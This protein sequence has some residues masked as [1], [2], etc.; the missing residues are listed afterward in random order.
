VLDV[1]GVDV[2]ALEE[3]MTLWQSGFNGTTGPLYCVAYLSGYADGSSRIYVAMHHLLVD[4]VSW[5]ILADDL[6]HLYEGQS[7]G[8]KGSSYRQWVDVLQDYAEYHE[9]E[10][11]YWQEVVADLKEIPALEKQSVLSVA[12]LELGEEF[13]SFLLREANGA[14]HTQINDLLLTALAYALNDLSGESVHHVTLEGHG[15]EDIA[16]SIDVTRTVG[17]FTSLYPVRLALGDDLG[18]S[19]KKIKDNI[20]QI[21]NKGIGYG[22]LL[23]YAIAQMPV[24]SFNYLGQFE[25]QSEF[26]HVVDEPSG[27]AMHSE[28]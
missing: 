27:Q 23:G 17:W 24:V 3:Q 4:A 11:A 5:R 25:Q 9:D 13:T 21:P 22:A 26:W 14:Y 28:N 19:I 12:E 10:R 8:A 7:L 18:H 15:R 20:R 2:A 1:S 6:H 16:A